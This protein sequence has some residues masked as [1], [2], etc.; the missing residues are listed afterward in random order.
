MRRENGNGSDDGSGV[1]GRVDLLLE[2]AET[3]FDDAWLAAF[4]DH[5][6]LGLEPV[7]G[8]AEDH[9]F[10]PRDPPGFD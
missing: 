7:A 5:G 9:R 3:R 1:I 10:V 2:L 8:N 4:T 6:F